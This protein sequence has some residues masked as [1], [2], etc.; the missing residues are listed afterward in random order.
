MIVG[1]GVSTFVFAFVAFMVPAWT[2]EALLP[3]TEVRGHLAAA[4]GAAVAAVVAVAGRAVAVRSV[5]AALGRLVM[6]RIL[7][8]IFRPGSS[9]R[10]G[11][12]RRRSRAF[13]IL[14][15]SANSATA[16]RFALPSNRVFN[17]VGVGG[18]DAR[19]RANQLFS[20]LRESGI[21]TTTAACCCICS[22]PNGASKSL[23]SRHRSACRQ[24]PMAGDLRSIQ[25]R[26]CRGSCRRRGTFLHR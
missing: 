15:L 17:H 21:P 16:A 6:K 4:V 20:Q 24:C 10:F 26:Y 22:S 18:L 3:A 11:F 23:R 14:S 2:R 9:D 1:F 8:N 5:A 7:Q 12:P 25:S 19:S 13:T